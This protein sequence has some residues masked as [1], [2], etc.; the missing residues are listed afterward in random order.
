MEGK[1]NLAIIREVGIGLRDTGIPI[2][3]FTTYETETSAALQVLS[4]ELAAQLIRDYKLC[5]VEDLEGQP[6]WVKKE[7]GVMR[8]LRAWKK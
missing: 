7:G 2:L 8:Y 5:D 3:W 4:W 6:C 1:E